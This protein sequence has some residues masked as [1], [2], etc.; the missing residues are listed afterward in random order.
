MSN[1]H[2]DSPIFLFGGT[3]NPVH[4]G[5]LRLVEN[6]HN[7]MPEAR[8]RMMPSATPPH[9]DEPDVSAEHRLNMVRLAT[10]SLNHVVV[11]DREL[12]RQG[13]SFTSI[14]VEELAKEF[15]SASLILV[16]GD[17]AMAG[18]QS[19]HQWQDI[20]QRVNILVIA[21]PG[22]T[23]QWLAPEVEQSIIRCDHVES[24]L[25]NKASDAKVETLSKPLETFKSTGRLYRYQCPLLDI[26]ATQIRQLITRQQSCRF[27]LPDSVIKYIEQHRLYH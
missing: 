18:F 6:L 20:I 27:L 26:S 7:L 2:P 1:R 22:A 9:R 16:M 11:D 17:D 25:H 21:R 15:P 13:P 23:Q 5:H 4:Y 12:K 3:F 10:E 8:V 19:W 14:S 24:L